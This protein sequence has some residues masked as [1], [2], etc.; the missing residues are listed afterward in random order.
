MHFLAFHA[1]AYADNFLLEINT[2]LGSPCH[3]VHNLANDVYLLC[4]GWLCVCRGCLL[5]QGM[6]GMFAVARR[7]MPEAQFRDTGH[8]PS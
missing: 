2:G 4:A 7:H 3:D 1:F 8:E 5:L 6:Q